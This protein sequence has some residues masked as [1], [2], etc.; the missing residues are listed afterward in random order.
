VVGGRN[1]TELLENNA[2]KIM[3]FK[4]PTQCILW[5][6]ANLTPA[7]LDFERVKTF[8]ES[9]HFD[10]NILKCKEC[11][12]LYFHEFY[13]IVNFGGDDDMYDTFIPVETNEEIKIL[14]ETK[15]PMELLQFS[16]RLQWDFVDGESGLPHWIVS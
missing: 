4:K 9:S 5:N 16:P 13:E 1:G 7:D 6:K 2:K 15:E 8:T 10:R 3:K 11:G 14:S 12:Q